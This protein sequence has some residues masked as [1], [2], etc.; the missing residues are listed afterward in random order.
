MRGRSQCA[1]RVQKC[2]EYGRAAAGAASAARGGV[3]VVRMAMA[4][5]AVRKRLSIGDVIVTT[6]VVV[7]R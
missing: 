4:A 3:M 1:S 2:I 6:V 5:M 7:D